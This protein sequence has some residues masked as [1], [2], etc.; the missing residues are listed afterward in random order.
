MNKHYFGNSIVLELY[1]LVMES[2]GH[3]PKKILST[4]QNLL[5]SFN[6]PLITREGHIMTS[7]PTLSGASLATS[8]WSAEGSQ[9]S[10]ASQD[11]PTSCTTP[12]EPTEC[13]QTNIEEDIKIITAYLVKERALEA[14]QAALNRI[15]NAYGRRIEQKTTEQAIRQL[16]AVV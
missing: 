14:V 8:Q 11:A 1:R 7:Q 4:L 15:S 13:S 12:P 6:K 2:H 10:N 5:P 3:T 16:Q 9:A